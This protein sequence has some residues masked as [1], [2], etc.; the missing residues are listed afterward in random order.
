MA[1]ASLLAGVIVPIVTPVD[2][3]DRV[4]EPAF[5]QLI[6][7]LIHAGVHG[8][9]VGGSAGEGPL[10]S[11]HQ[12]QRM[13]ELAFDQVDGRIPVLGGTADTSTA[14]VLAR[15]QQLRAIGFRHLTIMPTFY[16]PARTVDEQLRL[17][18]SC[19]EQAGEAQLIAYN[20]PAAT[21][22]ELQIETM[23]QL[24]ARG[25][26]SAIKESSGN[27]DYFWNVLQI[28]LEHQVTML[29]GDEALIASGLSAGGAG[30]VPVCANFEPSTFVAAFQAAQEGRAEDLQRYQSRIMLLRERA[31][32]GGDCWISGV[33]YAVSCLG[34]GDGRPVS[35]L[36]P[37]NDQQ[38]RA[39]DE[40]LEKPL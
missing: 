36:Q 31:P 21:G 2:T 35:P 14:R 23:R 27:P 30:I 40:I 29:V 32:K 39:I 37:L 17:F 9:F 18:E 25:W 4:D 7:H 12:W 24:C 38:R 16:T 20:L 3:Q 19:R 26:I 10:L 8:L 11:T 33:K 15:I 28:A 13:M 6:D 1:T 22:V 5:R 34:I